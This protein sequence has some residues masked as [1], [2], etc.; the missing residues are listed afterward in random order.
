M[1]G[2]GRDNTGTCPAMVRDT[3]DKRLET[4]ADCPTWSW[5]N[6]L[7]GGFA[8]GCQGRVPCFVGNTHVS[9]ELLFAIGGYPS[10]RQQSDRTPK[11]RVM[12]LE[13]SIN[14]SWRWARKSWPKWRKRVS[15]APVHH[16]PSACRLVGAH[17]AIG[18]AYPRPG[19]KWKRE[20]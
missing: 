1:T 5:N 7:K 16:K 19:A 6:E 12:K 2:T 9:P 10:W 18:A 8:S 11:Q 3:R 20:P 13:P 15:F 4:R 14:V 17:N